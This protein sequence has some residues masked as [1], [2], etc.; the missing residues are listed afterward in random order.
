MPVLM[1]LWADPQVNGWADDALDDL[2]VF[3]NVKRQG[4]AH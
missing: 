3:L 4:W 2:E 1:T